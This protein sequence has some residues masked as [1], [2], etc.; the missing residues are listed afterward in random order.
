[1]LKRVEVWREQ[2]RSKVLPASRRQIATHRLI[3]PA[4]CRQPTKHVRKSTCR[5]RFGLARKPAPEEIS[6]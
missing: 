6:A 5:G 2:D 3:L 4:R 1:M